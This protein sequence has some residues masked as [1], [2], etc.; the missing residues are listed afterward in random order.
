M[1]V[2][3]TG[4]GQPIASTTTGSTLGVSGKQFYPAGDKLMKI[5]TPLC[6]MLLPLTCGVCL[7]DTELIVPGGMSSNVQVEVSISTVLGSSSDDDS[8][9]VSIDASSMIVDPNPDVEPF[10]DMDISQHAIYTSGG[11]LV[12]EFFCNAFFCVEEMSVSLQAL[13]VRLMGDQT[14][15][16]DGAGNWEL[17]NTYYELD[18]VL[19]YEGSLVGTGELSTT[20]NAKVTVG[21]NIYADQ[22]SLYVTNLEMDT[23]NVTVP[24][25]SL[26]AGLNALSIDVDA[27]FSE[28]V[29]SGVYNTAD[30]DGD[31]QV[32]GSDL[33]ILLGNWGGCCSADLD[34]DGT[35]G[36]S[37]L[38]LLLAAWDC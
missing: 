23:I 9:T 29:Y 17:A 38:T 20:E 1:G 24:S 22:G 15:M 31:G 21:G 33:T 7:A 2:N 28:L 27:D 26:P 16:V 25:E 8:T 34:G 4:S 3:R 6:S 18:L 36:G 14:V 11:D 37:D 32:C 35:V 30:L 19:T 13:D 12:F 10:S 5:A